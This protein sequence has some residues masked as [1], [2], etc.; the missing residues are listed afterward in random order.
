M[1]ELPLQRPCNFIVM[2]SC[3]K[4]N[5]LA[6]K[7]SMGSWVTDLSMGMFIDRNFNAICALRTTI[8]VIACALRYELKICD[9]FASRRLQ[10]SP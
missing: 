1:V 3:L 2:G 5:P 6:W 10:K 9:G 8:Y 7:E 4:K